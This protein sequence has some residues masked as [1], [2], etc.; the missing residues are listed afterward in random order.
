MTIAIPLLFQHK[1]S[2]FE[3]TEFDNSTTFTFPTQKKC[4]EEERV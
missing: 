3:T 4:I 2:V 1:K